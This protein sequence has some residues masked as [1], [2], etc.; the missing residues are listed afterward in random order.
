MKPS[1]ATVLCMSEQ[2]KSRSTVKRYY[3]Q[4]RSTQGLPIRCETTSCQFHGGSLMW[5]GRPLGLI[6]DHISGNA[7]DNTPQNLRLLC[8][9]CDS[10]NTNTR[11]GANAGR[12]EV[13]P[14]GSYKVRNRDG[15]QDAFANGASFSVVASVQQGHVTAS[16]TQSGE[17]ARQLQDDSGA[18]LTSSLRT[19]S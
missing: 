7:K 13:D 2:P 11:G 14:S 3:M 9:N 10:Q 6:L 18:Q 19:R 17:D 8:P 5:N 12:I 4:W 15:T 1:L 16:V